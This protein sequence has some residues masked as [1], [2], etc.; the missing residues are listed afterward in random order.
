MQRICNALSQAGFMV[1]IYGIS[2][3]MQADL[4]QQPYRQIRL[5]SIF[6]KGKLFYVEY[7][8]RLVFHLL[9]N[10]YDVYT[11]IDLDTALPHYIAAKWHKKTM[12]LDA[13]EYYLGLPEIQH[14][15]FTKWLWQRLERFIYPKIKK[16]YTV[17]ES[18]AKL[19]ASEYNIEMTVVRNCPEITNINTIAKTEP[20]ILYQG[21][22]NEGRG[23]EE[24]I[25]AM[26]WVNMP[27]KIAGSGTINAALKK[28]VQT[29]KLEHKVQ[30]LGYILPKNLNEVTNNATIGV[31]LLKGN[32]LNYYY[33]L[34]NKFFD[35][36]HANIPQLSMDFPEY[37]L[38]NNKY[39]VAVLVENLNPKHIAKNLNKLI[40]N[41]N[42]YTKLSS[43][44]K[45]AKQVFNWQKEKEQLI[46][47]YKNLE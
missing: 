34:A 4:E 7:N 8:L 12:C 42:F 35:Y 46:Q 9:K 3:T 6:K 43:N 11:A 2:T 16:A 27:L 1:T 18:I 28:M 19:Y 26:Q 20:Y 5:K 45:V 17:N 25:K 33:S 32:C 37:R 30:F 47:F 24:L 40:S 36:M 38:I 39:E 23:L 44:C 14:R 22:L 41:E 29:L 21:A 15:P 10:R 31:N 13:H